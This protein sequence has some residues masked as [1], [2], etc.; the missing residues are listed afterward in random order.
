MALMMRRLSSM[1]TTPSSRSTVD[2][3]ASA[4]WFHPLTLRTNRKNDAGKTW[5]PPCDAS[6]RHAGA[7]N[8][9][10][11]AALLDPYQT[12]GTYGCRRL[13]PV[14]RHGRRDWPGS[15]QGGAGEGQGT[16]G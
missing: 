12:V 4:A 16:L 3:P 7:D 9:R 13:T 10:L 5:N 15:K 2:R 11:S 1:G 6:L 8:R 14:R